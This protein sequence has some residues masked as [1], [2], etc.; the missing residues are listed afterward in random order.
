MGRSNHFVE[1]E[2][3]IV[4]KDLTN[5]STEKAEEEV[6]PKPI[7]ES[8]M[9]RNFGKGKRKRMSLREQK[10]N[11]IEEMMMHARSQ[12][13]K[14]A[15]FLVEPKKENLC[16]NMLMKRSR[17]ELTKSGVKRELEG[18]EFSRK[19]ESKLISEVKSLVN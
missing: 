11:F 12:L 1:R 13:K 8:Q 4:F 7:A 5:F 3:A 17:K 19:E 6:E 16:N 2:K 15:E 9:N 14:E 10:D 18:F